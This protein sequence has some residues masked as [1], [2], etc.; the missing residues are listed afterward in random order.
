ML[1]AIQ[2]S[3]N[4]A[5]PQ[6]PRQ[7]F[8]TS[9]GRSYPLGATVDGKG[10]NFALFSA[11]AT[12]VELCLFDA[13][14]QNEIQRITLPEFTDE[15]W[16]VYVQ[17]LPE[18]SL[19]G[20]R[21][22]GAFDP[23]QGHRFNANKLLIDP[24]AKKL[25]GKF[26]YSD[27]H[28]GYDQY[29]EQHDLTIDTRDNSAYLPKC[30]VIATADNCNT[31]PQ[32]RRRDTLIYELHVK[33]FTQANP[34]VPVELQGT[35]AGLAEDNVCQYIKDLGITSIELL[36]I[37][38]FLD[39]PFLQEQGLS[40]YWG[41][42]SLAFFIPEP[43]YSHHN[44]I[45]EFR[46]LVEKYH[47]YGIEVIL[48]VVYNHTAEGDHLGPMLSFKGIDN[49]SY[50]RLNPSDKR[51]YINHSGCGNS[52]NIQHPRVL[53][54][55]TDSLRYWVEK[56][57]VDGFRFDLAPVLG[58]TEYG[59]NANSH[60]FSTLRQDPV[61]SRVKLI[62]EPWD[63]GENGYQLGRFP[64]SWLEWNDKFRDT[65]R[66]FWR[67]DQGMVPE[68]AQRLHGSSDLFE[69]PSRRPSASV[70]FISSHDGFTL[71]DLVTYQYKH[72]HANGEQNQDGHDSN[73]SYN[74][75]VEG[76]TPNSTINQLRSRQKR[77]LLTSLFIAQGTP[78]LLA[79]D[80]INNSQQGNNNA[81]CQDNII[82][83]LNWTQENENTSNSQIQQQTN[84]QLEFVKQLIA[85]RKE[86][87][88]LNRTHYHHG[89]EHSEKT[90]LADINWLNCH[91]ERMQQSDWHDSAIKCFAMLLGETKTMTTTSVTVQNDD[92]LLIIFNAHP[93]EINYHLPQQLCQKLSGYWQILI[94]TAANE[95]AEP[96][97]N[98]QHNSKNITHS[99]LC[100]AAHSCV[101][102]TY[103]QPQ[104]IQSKETNNDKNNNE[105]S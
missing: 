35:F 43:K 81:Y 63:I 14:G 32:V 21:V 61:L 105:P 11:N 2:K 23:H 52:L 80:E 41:Y 53:Q 8:Q 86:H 73:F 104:A 67:G 62:A 82:S 1:M 30:V 54:L 45:N 57:G 27:T 96:K 78:M 72:N 58:R 16:H 99:T 46:E 93:C 10:T 28:Y 3:I 92:A 33:G 70:N 89:K 102:L 34:N 69:N 26:I 17:G 24:Y 20:Y 85:L 13:S 97:H 50:Y 103:N 47:T 68:F 55:V 42:N 91:G 64:N 71:H 6:K 19:Y 56:M 98:D 87:P 60:F 66:R 74:F 36:P 37:H 90:G 48:D 18:G 39:E 22:H 12:K 4:K 49:A 83:W 9:S 77:N 100:I 88:L 40:N 65:C 5:K 31:H 94:N 79:G 38:T 29:H 95:A 59:F 25:F 7:D 76:E 101:V 15:V 84:Q 44:N 51:F 75:G